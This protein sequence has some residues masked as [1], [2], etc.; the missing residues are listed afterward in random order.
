MQI[1]LSMGLRLRHIRDREGMRVAVALP[2]C[3]TDRVP[4]AVALPLG[5]RPGRIDS[6][7]PVTTSEA[8][9]MRDSEKTR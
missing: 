5:N 9:G 3:G 2:K 1:S 7:G 6:D 8:H 4:G